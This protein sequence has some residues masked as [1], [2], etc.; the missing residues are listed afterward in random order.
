M[1]TPDAPDLPS[2]ITTA[3]E[4]LEPHFATH[5]DGIPRADAHEILRADAEVIEEDADATY[6]LDRLLD[7]GWLYEV[8]GAVRKTE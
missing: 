2:W 5:P 8:N 7:R 3:Y 6:A 1:W 4:S